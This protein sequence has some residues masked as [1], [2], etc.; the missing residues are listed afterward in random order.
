MSAPEPLSPLARIRGF[1]HGLAEVA[2][3]LRESTVAILEVA[4]GNWPRPYGPDTP[5]LEAPNYR[6]HPI[7]RTGH[8]PGNK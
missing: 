8:I 6:A 4:L 7:E 1:F 5:K 2:E 3:F